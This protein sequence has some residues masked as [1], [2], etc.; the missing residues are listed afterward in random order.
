MAK[1]HGNPPTA[2]LP[3]IDP[4]ALM[5]AALAG[6]SFA[7]YTRGI[8]L[9]GHV[10][11]G[12]SGRLH[13]DAT[14]LETALRQGLTR[15]VGARGTREI[16]LGL[17][18]GRPGE[19]QVML[20]AARSLDS[21]AVTTVP[22]TNMTTLWSLP[23]NEAVGLPVAHR[24]SDLA[25]SVLLP[26]TRASLRAGPRVGAYW[27]DAFRG[28][29]LLFVAP[30]LLDAE[31]W[32]KSMA[33]LGMTFAQALD[34]ETA[35]ALAEKGRSLGRAPDLV[36]LDGCLLGGEV[37]RLARHFRADPAL[38]SALIILA[39][40]DPAEVRVTDEA[41]AHGLFDAVLRPPMAWRR[42][43]DTL[44]DLIRA[45]EPTPTPRLQP[46]H[47]SA[48]LPG[49]SGKRILI[50]EDVE[51]NQ[52]LLRA[53]LE[54]TGAEVEMVA[55]GAALVARHAE[56]PADLILVDLQM[57][58]MG[59]LAAIRRIREM[60]GNAGQVRA[61]ALTAYAGAADRR[62]ALAAGI[63]AY[64]AKPVMIGEFYELLDRLLV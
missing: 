50:A 38:A 16:A 30:L 57:P 33:S 56:A 31:R 23:G 24:C 12:L 32:A 5:R 42:L 7:A 61:V 1:M 2:P 22:S 52:V 40:E 28:R 59:G 13:G 55:D 64:L 62:A 18:R 39:A 36:V 27:G 63:D 20:E 60:P 6:V 44:Y 54:P 4:E 9:L 58:R 35:I 8:A 10:D 19:A 34:A 53:M 25:E 21:D 17:W 15:T 49:L 43:L 29:R 45:S 3:G 26:L 41:Q 11:T 47:T 51:T 37:S 14:A 46:A 48:R